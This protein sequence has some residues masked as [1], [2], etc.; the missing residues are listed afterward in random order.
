MTITNGATRLTGVNHVT[1]NVKD[2]DKA[3][4]FWE[5]V[6]GIKQIPSQVQSDRIIWLQLPDG[7][8]VHLVQNE[9]GPSV[10]NHHA[11]FEVED[12]SGY[13][14]HIVSNDVEASEIT[15]R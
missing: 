1:Y 6:L 14:E 5:D 11:A 9:A 3:L 15:T 4:L 2:K 12:I 7:T 8:M 10:P 13:R